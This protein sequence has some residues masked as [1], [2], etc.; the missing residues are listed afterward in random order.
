[1]TVKSPS[2]PLNFSWSVEDFILHYCVRHYLCRSGESYHLTDLAKG[3][4]T[5]RDAEHRRR[6]RYERWYPLLQE[7]LALLNK[8]GRTHLI[9]VGRVVG[10]FLSDKGLSDQVE[11]VLQYSRAA[12]AHRNRAVQ[13][14]AEDFAEFR[15]GFDEEAFRA[16]VPGGP[17]RQPVGS[18]RSLQAGGRPSVLCDRIQ[19]E[20]HVLLQEPF[21]RIEERQPYSAP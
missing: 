21:W 4:M 6:E 3:G 13:Q 10:N 15:C 20:A 2:L 14:W 19:D 16:S 11:R 5:V 8:P 12:A 17:C 9:A 18:L 1:M 7:E